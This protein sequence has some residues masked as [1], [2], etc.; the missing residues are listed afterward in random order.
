M[1]AYGSRELSLQHEFQGD[2]EANQHNSLFIHVS[3]HLTGSSRHGQMRREASGFCVSCFIQFPHHAHALVCFV[4][5]L[6]PVAFVS[7]HLSLAPGVQG[8]WF[9]SPENASLI[10]LKG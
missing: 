6:S 1:T 2:S 5:F 8:L 9:A 7:P 10:F 4:L 3:Q